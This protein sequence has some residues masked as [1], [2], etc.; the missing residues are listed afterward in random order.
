MN[1]K[2]S[3]QKGNS[4]DERSFSGGFKDFCQAYSLNHEQF[5]FYDLLVS[6]SKYLFYDLFL[7]ML[8]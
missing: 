6:S 1:G 3:S 7:I 4:G 8:E 2:G 5:P